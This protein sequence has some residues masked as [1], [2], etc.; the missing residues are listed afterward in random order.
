MQENES[1]A[2]SGITSVS[3]DEITNITWQWAELTENDPAA[4]SLV[5]DPENYT[6]TF[7]DDGSFSFKADCNSGSGSLHR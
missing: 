4:Q 1:Q 2:A 7:W 6:L 3:I 5:P